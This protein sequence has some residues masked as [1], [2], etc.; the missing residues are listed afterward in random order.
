MRLNTSH[1]YRWSLMSAVSLALAGQAAYAATIARENNA[2]ALNLGSAWQ[3]TVDGDVVPGATDIALW[4]S[5][6]LAPTG[7]V[8]GTN[9]TW[10]QIQVTNPAGAAGI[11]AGN[12][13]TLNGVSGVGI[14]MSAATADFGIASGVTLGGSQSWNV[15]AGRL[16]QVTTNVQGG[17]HSLTKDG[18]GTLYL[19]NLYSTPLTINA[20][21]VRTGQPSAPAKWG[22]VDI[23]SG[24]ILQIDN[25]SAARVTGLTGSGIV[26]HSNG[27]GATQA[28]SIL[29]IPNANEVYV[30]GGTIRNSSGGKALNVSIDNNASPEP[31]SPIGTQVFTGSLEYTGT[32]I[33]R[34]ATVLI[35]GTTSGLGAFRLDKH[36][37]VGGT[38]TIGLASNIEFRIESSQDAQRSV[39]T[40]GDHRAGEDPIGELTIGTA[41]NNNL[42]YFRR[43]G[44]LLIELDGAQSDRLNVVGDLNLTPTAAGPNRLLVDV[45]GAPTVGTYTIVTYTGTLTGTFGDISSLT[46]L[47]STIDYGTGTNSAITIAVPEPGSL[48]LLA[49]A[50]LLAVKR[51]RRQ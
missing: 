37:V 15:G 3:D 11:L 27:G 24:A 29:L 7:S 28:R 17:G 40:P 46:E 48:C 19:Q 9:T 51:R 6:I 4:D 10:G 49:G 39:L 23:K 13:L 18:A 8:L 5:A 31:T 36:G 16:L 34:Y 50:G 43:H 22:V 1:C 12:T 38:G 21:A 42:V 44:T 41:G 47:G 32:T 25:N 20:G 45:L 33:V 14:D 26:E 30:F 35:N 2:D